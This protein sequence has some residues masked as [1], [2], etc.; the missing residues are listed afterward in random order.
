MTASNKTQQSRLSIE[1]G[2]KKMII[3]MMAVWAAKY[4][5]IDAHAVS[6]SVSSLDQRL[7][8]LM[9][10]LGLDETAPA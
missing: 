3:W 10:V 6:K 1:L 9:A 8:S 7:R 4:A 2:R 5:P